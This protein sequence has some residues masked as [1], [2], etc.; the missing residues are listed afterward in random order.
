MSYENTVENGKYIVMKI[1]ITTG[2]SIMFNEMTNVF[3][4]KGRVQKG[5]KYIS[6]ESLPTFS[7]ALKIQRFQA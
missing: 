2:M 1:Y 7:R 5:P 4:K 3:F 6:L